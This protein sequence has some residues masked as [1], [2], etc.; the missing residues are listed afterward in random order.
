MVQPRE[1]GS[2]T[3]PRRPLFVATVNEKR[4]AELEQ[5]LVELLQHGQQPTNTRIR[6]GIPTSQ[7]STASRTLL[8]LLVS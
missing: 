1:R 7:I 3:L 2:V 5:S 8:L 6:R 4:T